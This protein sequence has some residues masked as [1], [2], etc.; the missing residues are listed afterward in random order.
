MAV[1]WDVWA[2]AMTV[3]GDTERERNITRAKELFEQKVEANP[4][5]REITR[6]GI[7]QTLLITRSDVR[8]KA[9][10]I[11][12]P[13][14]ELYVGDEVVAYGEHWIVMETRV[15]DD[16]QKTGLMW[17]CNHLYRWQ[18]F[19]STVVEHWGVLDSGV[20]S[21]TKAGDAQI[22]YPDQQFKMFL[23]FNEDTEKLFVDKRFAAG[24]AYNAYNEPILIVYKITALD[25]SSRSY[26]V[27]GHLLVGYLRSDTFNP[28]RDNYTL[29]ICDYISPATPPSPG[30]LLTCEITG[31]STVRVGSNRVYSP[32]F[33]NAAG[34]IAV[35]VTPE[36]TIQ[37]VLDGVELREDGLNAVISI[38]PKDSLIGRILTLTLGASGYDEATKALE[39]VA[40]G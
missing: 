22:Q 6:N 35:G 21:T 7:A 10:V 29:K 27:G 2:E 19:D 28:D 18:N 25:P 1:N 15:V 13:G 38:V 23:S 30:S 11:A 32:V 37:P 8:Y 9:N 33:Y 39:V 34:E 16:I 5:C 3:N 20:Y 17:L 36:W 40:V 14:D 4:G 26:G 12:Y 31:R 24:T